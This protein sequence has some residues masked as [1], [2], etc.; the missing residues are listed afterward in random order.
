MLDAIAQAQAEA[1]TLRPFLRDVGLGCLTRRGYRV[2][3]LLWMG[4]TTTRAQKAQVG[5]AIAA[6]LIRWPGHTGPNVG[7]ELTDAGREALK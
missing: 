7:A 2:F 1:G 5:Q 6:G 3:T 4:R